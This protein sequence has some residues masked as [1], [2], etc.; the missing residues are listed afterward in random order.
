MDIRLILKKILH[1][2]KVADALLEEHQRK[3]LHL[4][5]PLTF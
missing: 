2:E 4:Q 3:A 5:D 1:V